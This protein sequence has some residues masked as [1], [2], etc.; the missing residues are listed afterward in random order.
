T[1]PVAPTTA[2]QTS[3]TPAP[4][5]VTK[6]ASGRITITAAPG[7][8]L[9]ANAPLKTGDKV[10]L[11][12]SG[13]TPN[14]QV[15]LVLHS[16]PITIGTFRADGQGVVLA[17]VTL[18]AGVEAGQH[19][20]VGTDSTG[21]VRS[22]PLTLSATSGASGDLAYTGADP[23]AP[24]IGGAALLVLGGGLVLMTRRRRPTGAQV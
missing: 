10:T 14:E 23:T 2:T 4:A 15:T 19:N 21:V 5:T 16:K 6:D 17:S 11:R 12:L 1:T 18:P 3:S 20:L 24:L 13:F 22:Y 7:Q 8:N 9:T